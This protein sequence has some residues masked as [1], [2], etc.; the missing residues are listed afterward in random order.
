[1]SL[2]QIPICRAE[3]SVL[4]VVDIQ[5]R[6]AVAMPDAERAR[7]VRNTGILAQAAELLEIPKLLTEQ[8]PKGLG[9]TEPAVREQL[10]D[11]GARRFEKTSFSC[12]GAGDFLEAL[13]ATGRRQVILAGMEAHVCVLQTALELHAGG[14]EVYVAGDATCSRNPQ[15]HRN[16]ME[17]LKQAGVAVTNTESV[18]FEWLRDSSHKHFKAISGLLR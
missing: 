18:V 6:L 16:A 11:S 2:E 4:L 1:M 13:R 14:L 15:N 9:P 12:C 8:Y 5:Q 17:R 3:N 10:G 7:V